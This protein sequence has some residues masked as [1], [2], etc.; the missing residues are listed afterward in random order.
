MNRTNYQSNHGA[1]HKLNKIWWVLTAITLVLS[2]IP[3]ISMASQTVMEEIQIEKNP[4]I[5]KFS[6][7]RNT[8][9][10]IIKLEKKELLIALKNIELSEKFQIKGREK[11]GIKHIGIETLQGN[12][13]AVILTG[14]Q[15]FEYIQS[16]FNQSGSVF[17]INLEKKEIPRE[18]IIEPK[19]KFVLKPVEQRIKQL[20]EKKRKVGV[21]QKPA[22]ILTPSVYI[23]PKREK[24]KYRGDISDIV[25]EI[26]DFKCDSKQIHSSIIFLK[27]N[28]FAKAF[29]LIDQYIVQGKSTC[30]EQAYY[31]KA[32]AFYENVKKDDFAQLFK[33]EQLF[34]EALVSYPGSAYIPYGYVSIGM[35]QKKMNNISAALGYFN[36]VKQGYPEYSGIPEIIFHLADIYD[37]QGYLDKALRYYRQ[38]FEETIENDYIQDAGIGYGRALFRKHRY[39]D[40]LMILNYVAKLNP[41]K[42]YDSH[43]L[44]LHMGNANFE[45]GNNKPA[46]INLTRLLNLFPEIK[47]PDVILSRIG[48]TYG[49]ENNNAQAIKIYELVREKFPDSKG[50]IS[51]SIGIARYLETDGEKIEIYEMIKNKFPEDKYARIAMMRLAEIYQTN[52]E[53]NKCIK[54]IE[55]LLSTNP[56]GLRYEAVQLMQMAYEALFKKKLKSDEY[57]KILNRY[58]LEHTRIDRMGSRDIAL[59][60][61]L[62]YLHAK[63]YEES[64]NHLVNAYKQYTRS[65]RPSQLLFGLGVAMDESG[66][67]DDALKLFD[68]FSKQFPESKKRGEV[69]LRAGNIYFDKKR[70]K[71]ASSKFK[72]AYKTAKTHLEKGEVLLLHSNI[73]E[74]KSD[75]K[76]AV[77]FRENA[78]KEL[79]LASGE[80]YEILT[81][82]HKQL[83]HTYIYLKQYIKS[84][85]SYRKALSFSQDNKEKANLGFL[86]GDAYQQGNILPKA[87]KAFKQVVEAYDSIWARMAQQ[88]LST[89][90]LA[91]M[92]QNS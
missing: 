26:E 40:S 47:N 64:F 19:K 60:V 58:E 6:M 43:E 11:S 73:Y 80:N 36:I 87:K 59:S 79:A 67:D 75:M 22:K 4:L 55:D 77:E 14:D 78:I 82:A 1:N 2:A 42:I 57:T 56:K 62:A 30:L 54:E 90:E 21:L 34:Q 29:D 46:R 72:L 88:R 18:S 5:V 32:Y 24:T 81:K 28:M 39:L 71:L 69:L 35:I 7:T 16:G 63:L 8:P 66:R 23:P 76:T 17:S 74:K 61:G 68:A 84:A 91:Q 13:L 86:V 31:L 9:V 27:K 49:M 50:Y 51:S 65:S 89:L 41:K 12:V 15:P 3:H 37:Q 70:Y 44:L 20:P 25:R 53:H 48:D 38:I 10:K 45:I 83:G 92:A 52:G 85:D 33:A